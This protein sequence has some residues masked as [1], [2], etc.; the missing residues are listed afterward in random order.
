LATTERG[1][2]AKNGTQVPERTDWHN[3]VM[4]GGLAE[5]AHKYL[6]KGSKVYVEGKIRTRSYTKEGTTETRY[7]TEVMVDNMEMLT[8]PAQQAAP[9]PIPQPAANPAQQSVQTPAKD[10][11]QNDLPF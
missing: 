11:Y 10:P 6:H 5:I 9:A 2:T 1:Y 7:V 4:W 3:I 8:P